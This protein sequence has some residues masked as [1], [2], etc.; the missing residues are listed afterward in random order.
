MPLGR[1][2]KKKRMKL[3]GAHQLLIYADD[4][5]LLGGNLRYHTEKTHCSPYM[6]TMMKSRRIRWAEYVA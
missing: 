1:C 3:N 5:S 4:I 6:I 2:I